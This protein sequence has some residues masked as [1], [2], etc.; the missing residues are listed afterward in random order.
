MR[1]AP[2]LRLLVCPVPISS[3]GIAVVPTFV[4]LALAT[5]ISAAVRLSVMAATIVRAWRRFVLSEAR[6]GEGETEERNY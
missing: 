6:E 4:A 3:F 5:G 1:G 2:R